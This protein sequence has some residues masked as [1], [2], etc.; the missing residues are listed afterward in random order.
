MGYLYDSNVDGGVLGSLDFKTPCVL[1]VRYS[2][3]MN[4]ADVFYT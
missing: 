2:I 4:Y 3:I 1:I